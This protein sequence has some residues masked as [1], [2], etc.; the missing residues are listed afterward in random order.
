[1]TSTLHLSPPI[2]R[3]TGWLGTLLRK[4]FWRRNA[5]ATLL[6]ERHREAALP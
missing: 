3:E 1:M 2:T 6:L 5:H 4:R